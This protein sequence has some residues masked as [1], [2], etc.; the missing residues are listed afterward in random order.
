MF[1][2]NTVLTLR[3]NNLRIQNSEVHIFHL[4]IFLMDVATDVDQNMHTTADQRMRI[5]LHLMNMSQV[6][7]SKTNM[8]FI[9]EAK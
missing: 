5:S 8:Y 2:T 1:C 4:I 9:V 6:N 3:K 7:N